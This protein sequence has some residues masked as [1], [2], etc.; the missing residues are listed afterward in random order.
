MKRI[1]ATLNKFRLPLRLAPW[2]VLDKL[3]TVAQGPPQP[4]SDNGPGHTTRVNTGDFVGRGVTRLYLAGPAVSS[5]GVAVAN[6]VIIQ[7]FISYLRELTHT[8][9]ASQSMG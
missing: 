6:E 1:F 8:A 9:L 7:T 2:V 5:K 3:N 4:P